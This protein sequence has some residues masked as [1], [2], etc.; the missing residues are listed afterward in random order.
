VSKLQPH[1]IDDHFYGQLVQAFTGW[2]RDDRIVADVSVREACSALLLRE[3][4]HLDNGEFE[5][6]LALFAPECAYWAP[7]S[8]GGASHARDPRKEIA[9]W[10]DDRRQLEGRIFRL[11]TGHAWSQAPASRTVHAVSN[12][13]VFDADRADT[14]MVRS[15]LL[16]TEF[17][18]GSTRS[19]AGWCGHRLKYFDGVLRILVKQVN[20]LECD[21]SLRNPSLII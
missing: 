4:R 10:F 5:Q 11:R 17:R 14:C 1:Y 18:A 16:V 12:I 3:A 7:G 20:L 2:Q 13:E 15:N 19:L 21:Q 8:P 6:W 9:M